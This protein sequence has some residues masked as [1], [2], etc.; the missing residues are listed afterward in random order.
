MDYLYIR[1][2][3]WHNMGYSPAPESPPATTEDLVKAAK[4]DW[5]VEAHPMFTQKFGATEHYHAIA[6]TDSEAGILGVVNKDPIITQNVDAFSIVDSILNNGL[7]VETAGSAMGGQIV[8]ASFKAG[9][10]YKLL[11]DDV[12]QYF[13]ILNEHLKP[14]GCVTVCHTP[15]RVVCQNVLTAAISKSLYSMRLAVSNIPGSREAQAQRVLESIGSAMHNMSINAEKM[16]KEKITKES[17]E[18]LLSE[19]FPLVEEVDTTGDHSKANERM[20]IAREMFISDCMGADN[21]S[22]YRGTFYQVYNAVV[23]WSQHMYSRATTAYDTTARM[24]SI[25]GFGSDGTSAMV[26]KVMRMR[27]QLVG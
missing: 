17:I 3:P 15:V 2:T 5:E 18:L 8:F 19:M 4:L 22:N 11:D 10:A 21:L 13:L 6:R 14:D 24:K 9:N 25:P 1:E 7:T 26:S 12:D 20:M 16:I 27:K 23:D